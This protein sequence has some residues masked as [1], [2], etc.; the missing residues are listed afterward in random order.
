MH[1][2]MTKADALQGN[3]GLAPALSAVD[4]AVEE[5][6]RDVVEHGH[7]LDEV[8]LLEDEAETGGAKAGELTIVHAAGV[9]TVD[10]HA[11]RAGPV[12]GAR[13]VQQGG[14]AGSGRSHHGEQLT[15]L[16]AQR[17]FSKRFDR[18]IAR[19]APDDVAQLDDGLAHDR[20]TSTDIPS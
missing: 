2:A 10:A 4:S 20:G 5:A 3:S 7:A 12:E 8:E 14:L 9:D 18:W 15:R 1:E 17:P 6:G 19:I 16:D 13:D 11:P